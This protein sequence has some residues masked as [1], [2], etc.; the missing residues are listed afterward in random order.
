MGTRKYELSLG[1]YELPTEEQYIAALASIKSD[2]RY[3]LAAISAV[4]NAQ[5]GAAHRWIF[6]SLRL[7]EADLKET[8]KMPRIARRDVVQA[9]AMAKFQVVLFLIFTKLL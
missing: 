4:R 1:K 3:S 6:E 2:P 5:M 8:Q 7:I 9:E